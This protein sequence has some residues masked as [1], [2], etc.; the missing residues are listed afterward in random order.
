MSRVAFAAVTGLAMLWLL[1]G[2]LISAEGRTTR[3]FRRAALP[4]FL[5]AD[6]AGIFF[7]DVFAQ[8]VSGP[9]PPRF[10]PAPARV[11]PP[12]ATPGFHAPPEPATPAGLPAT[13]PPAGSGPGSGNPSPPGR[14]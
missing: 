12:P 10:A 3:S 1:P 9:R 6:G 8:G 4:K 7:V 14:E 13:S 11:S 5:P 2:A